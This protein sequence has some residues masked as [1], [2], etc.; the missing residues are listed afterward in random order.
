MSVPENIRRVPRPKNTVVIDSG[1]T[2]PLRYAVR[3]RAGVK[4]GPQGQSRPINGSVIGHICE[5]RFVPIGEITRIGSD[6]PDTRSYGAAA[7]V[8]SESTD[9][10]QSLLAVYPP[11][12]AYAILV[13][14]MLRAIKPEIKNR[15]LSTE[16]K[17]TFIG[18][19]YPGV[20]ISE[21]RVSKLLNLLGQD[22]EKRA[23]FYRLRL[24]AVEATHHLV[25][26]GVLKQD[27]SVINSLSA[28]SYKARIKGCRD[29][30]VIYAY[31]LEKMEPVCAE[32][33]AGNCIDANAFA[34]FVRDRGIQ[35]GIIVAD[36][37]F[38]PS[39]ITQELNAR[40]DLHF[41]IPIRRNDRRI[42]SN[43][44]LNFQGVL[45]GIDRQVSYCKQ[46]IRGGRFLYAF[47][48]FGKA[49]TEE[50]TFLERM[51]KDPSITQEDFLRKSSLFGVIVFESDQD[52][53]PLDV[54]LCYEDRWQ[55]EL[56]F[57]SFKNDEG[58]DRTDV[59][60][61]Y[62]VW[63]NEFINFIATVLTCR[64]KRRAQRAGLLAKSSF[65]DLLED[66]ACAWRKTKSPLPPKSGDNFWQAE[67]TGLFALLEA[68]KLCI[69]GENSKLPHP[70]TASGVV[71]PGKRGRPRI[72]PVFVGPK[73]PRGR[74]R[75]GD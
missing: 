43:G 40:P 7:F 37:G 51:K 69:P 60:G 28:F 24:A 42:Q 57:D 75:K 44:M 3:Q 70:V 11:Q 59:Q 47:R 6:G 67:F 39:K 8:H 31:D 17:K 35:R 63:G 41:L 56:V 52:L 15:R 64:M 19:F 29:I 66:L 74:P 50:Y 21:N 14:A 5:G 55:I 62:S 53:P 48:D 16:Y 68:L 30:S 10:L 13:I 73:R 22:G 9:L 61:D 33:F 32:V 18:Q 1:H 65:K 72:R 4:Y 58:L 34:A 27:T 25:I 26:D 71:M 45:S 49:R 23:A 12:D 54:Y 20:H 2:G 38:P 46:Q 36:K